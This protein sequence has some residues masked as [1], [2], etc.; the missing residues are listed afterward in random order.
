MKAGPKKMNFPKLSKS[1]HFNYC[2]A[3]HPLKSVLKLEDLVRNL[4]APL[5]ELGQSVGLSYQDI[6]L[7]GVNIFFEY[8]ENAAVDLFNKFTQKGI[9]YGIICTERVLGET[10]N[11]YSKDNPGDWLVTPEQDPEGKGLTWLD[12]YRNF[13]EVA[14]KAQFI[15]CIYRDSVPALQQLLGHDR[16]HYLPLGYSSQL[17]DGP[18]HRS[19]RREFDLFFVG[20]TTPYRSQILEKLKQAGL[21]VSHQEGYLPA[22]IRSSVLARSKISLSLKMAPDWA[23]PSPNRIA[24][25]LSNEACVVAEKMDYVLE[26]DNYIELVESD[27]LIQHC[28]SLIES[29]DWETLGTKNAQ[30]FRE[31][32]NMTTLMGKLLSEMTEG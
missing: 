15:W 10:L 21:T 14:K 7:Q 23:V 19:S 9:P 27:E 11:G 13:L 8:F 1:Q 31:E 5:V 6:S 2:V 32:L 17:S 28:V 3:N 24:Y 20:K 4:Q 12:R 25:L 16:V 22:Y 30:R 29:G 18:V 26:T